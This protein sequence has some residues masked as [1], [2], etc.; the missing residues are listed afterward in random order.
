MNSLRRGNR[1]TIFL[2]F[3]SFSCAESSNVDYIHCEIFL[4]I[5][6]TSNTYLHIPLFAKTICH[7]GKIVII[8]VRGCKIIDWMFE[9]KRH[10]TRNFHN[11]FLAS[12]SM[13]PKVGT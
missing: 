3:I 8:N 12:E 13:R 4:M 6:Y 7:W 11:E 10:S 5:K 9:R 1:Y 2:S